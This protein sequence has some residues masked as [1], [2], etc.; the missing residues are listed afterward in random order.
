MTL[1]KGCK[2]GAMPHSGYLCDYAALT[3]HSR[4]GTVD[5]C[6]VRQPGKREYKPQQ[7][8]IVPS[9]STPRTARLK[10]TGGR[11]VTMDETMARILYDMGQNDY[12]IS[13]AT[14]AAQA[15]VWNWRTKEGLPANGIRGGGRPEKEA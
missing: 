10:S 7:I 12:E 4:G 9:S 15:T 6:T 14:G 3:G 11:K 13:A 8:A 5:D 1:C 2:Y